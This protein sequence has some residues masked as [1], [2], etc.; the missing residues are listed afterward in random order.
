M[1]AQATQKLSVHRSNRVTLP[2]RDK[3]SFKLDRIKTIQTSHACRYQMRNRPM[4]RSL[5]KTYIQSF[6]IAIGDGTP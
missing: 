2:S 6:D 1:N 3:I 4:A 5:L